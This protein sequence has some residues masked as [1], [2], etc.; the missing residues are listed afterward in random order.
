MTERASGIIMPIFSLPS[1]YG[2]GTLGKCAYDFVDFLKKSGTRYWQVL[3]LGPT[4]YGDSPYQSFSSFAGNPYFIDLDMLID[5][6]LLTK[7]DASSVVW[8]ETDE[9]IDYGTIY[10]NRFSVL[11][12]AYKNGFD[13]DKEAVDSFIDENKNWIYNYGVYMSLKK[14]NDMK[15]WV[16]FDDEDLRMHDKKAIEKFA[17]EHEDDVNFYIYI[18]FLFYRQWEKLREYAHENDVKIIGD[19]PIY[20]ALDSADVYSEPEYFALDEKNNPTEVAGVPPDYFSEDGQLWGNPLYDW[21]AMKADGYGWWIRRIGGAAKLYDCIRIDHFRGFESYWAV[22]ADSKTAKVGKWVKGPGIELVNMLTSWFSDVEFIAEDLGILT[23][24]VRELLTDSGLP[25]MK[26]LEFAFSPDDLSLYL[27]HNIPENSVCY[28]GTHDNDTLAGW[29]NTGNTGEIKFAKEYLGVKSK[30]NL[31][32][33][34]IRAGMSSRANLFVCQMQDWLS[35]DSSARINTPG[36][37]GGNWT[38][39]MKKDTDLDDVAEKIK[40]MNDIYQR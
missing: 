16:D 6:G 14:H 24:E 20:V 23:D 38:W 1:N 18:Q 7:E 26:V 39:R 40:R 31:A 32:E 3:P 21:D 8:C 12:K 25:G 36:T 9:K 22:P 15:C 37:L 34:V 30:K 28:V 27:P 13:R 17:R 35:L 2:I 19:I 10:N 5:D 33:G 11:Y 4:S 29:I